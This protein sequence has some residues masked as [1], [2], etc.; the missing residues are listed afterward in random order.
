MTYE[1]ATKC[2]LFVDSLYLHQIYSYNTQ[3]G[4]L[5]FFENNAERFNEVASD[6]LTNNVYYINPGLL[7]F[8]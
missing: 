3:T 7:L 5:T 2:L 1:Y 6:P 4:D 8:V